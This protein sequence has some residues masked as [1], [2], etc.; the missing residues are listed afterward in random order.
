MSEKA[1]KTT[2]ATIELVVIHDEMGD[3]IGVETRVSFPGSVLP[4]GVESVAKVSMTT[5]QAWQKEFLL[6]SA[7]QKDT[8]AA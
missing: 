6:S 8:G 2:F 7:A 3:P 1:K 4:L 5:N